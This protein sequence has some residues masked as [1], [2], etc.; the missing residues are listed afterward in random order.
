[1]ALSV[2]ADSTGAIGRS[3]PV[4]ELRRQEPAHEGDVGRYL[5]GVHLPGRHQSVRT[6]FPV[7]CIV[8]T[9]LVASTTSSKG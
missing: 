6:T 2:P 8:S 7:F 5:V 1:M 9:Y 4:R 3:H